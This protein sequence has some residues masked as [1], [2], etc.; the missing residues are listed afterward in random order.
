MLKK[1][2]EKIFTFV[3]NEK[4]ELLLLKG[5]PNDPQ[6]M[7]SFWYVVTGSC[8]DYDNDYLDAVKR[9]VKEETNLDVLESTYLNWIFKYHS[10]GDDCVER[11]YFSKVKK[12]TII[13]NEESIGYKWCE[14]EEFVD[15]IKWYEDKN[16]LIKVLKDAFENKVYFKEEQIEEYLN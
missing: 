16:I 7:E 6:F 11:V 1:E 15:L 5:G 4:N 14:L 3:V 2:I 13:L 9:E 8:E 12:D 10:L